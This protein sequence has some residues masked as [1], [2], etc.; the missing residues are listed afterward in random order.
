M[1]RLNREN[2]DRK[3]NKPNPRRVE[4]LHQDRILN[5]D[6]QTRRDDDVIRSN[7]RTL[8]DID[9]AIK[10]YIENEIQ[11]QITANQELIN[12]PVIFANGEKWDN[13]QRLG[14]LR[15]EKG[16]LQSPLIIL[17]RNSVQE[18]DS[19]RKLDVNWPNAD[20]QIIHRQR[21]NERNR[22]EDELFPIPLQQPAESQKIYIIDIPRYVT[23]EYDMMI[24]C[25]FTTQ[26]ND[27][28]D[29]I[30]PYSRFAWG[31]EGNKYVTSMGSISTETVNTTG[32]DRLVRATIPLTVMGTLLA[33]QQTRIDTVRKMYSI[34]KVSFDNVVDV[35]N[36]N[37]FSTTNVPQPVLQQSS[38][39]FAGGRI[40]VTGGGVSTTIN[41]AVMTYLINV[42][43]QPGTRVNNT[44][45]IV[46]ALAA[47]NP[48]NLAVATV[49]E[50]DIFINGQYIDKAVYTW[51]PSDVTTQTITFNTALLGYGI[52]PT[53][54]VIVKGR[55]Q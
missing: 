11:P 54:T 38:N 55:W 7:Q 36:L 53:D 34:K 49:N 12:V 45:V 9:Y 50:F 18:R 24:W 51:T 22:Y 41:A 25:D 40:T 19:H 31:N 13:V 44:T 20:N 15:D 26:L 46:A 8:Y 16:M 52:D 29:Q 48:N 43:E 17:K 3:T 33:A 21:Y 4:S 30:F 37:I 39:V 32:E 6:Q 14:Y 47:I 27:L 1:P 42:T 35:G 5:R 2:I 28:I 23:I 10:W